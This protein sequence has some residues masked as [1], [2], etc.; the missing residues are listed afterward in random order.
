[1][2]RSSALLLAL[3]LVFGVLHAVHAQSGSQ[4]QQKQSCKDILP[5]EARDVRCGSSVP[6]SQH[7]PEVTPKNLTTVGLPVIEQ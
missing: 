5:T 2:L 7:S 3:A 4:N 1:M 6:G